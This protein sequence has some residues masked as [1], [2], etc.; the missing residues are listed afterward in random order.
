[1]ALEV[2]QEAK[3]HFASRSDIIETAILEYVA[4]REHIILSNEFSYRL[5]TLAQE[6]EMTLS[7]IV[8]SLCTQALKV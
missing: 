2:Y 8:E 3:K 7:E 4:D 1:M 6:S 5:E